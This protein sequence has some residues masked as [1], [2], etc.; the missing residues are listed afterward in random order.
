M[1]LAEVPLSTR[2]ATG[3][4]RVILRLASDGSNVVVPD[5]FVSSFEF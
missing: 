5:I 4:V 2:G 3:Y 1:P